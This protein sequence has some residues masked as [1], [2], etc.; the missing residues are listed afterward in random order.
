MPAAQHRT[1]QQ[2]VTELEL[3]LGEIANYYCSVL[4]RNSIVKPQCLLK[5][6]GRPSERTMVF[7]LLVL[8]L[9]ISL[10]IKLQPDERPEDLYERLMAFIEDNLLLRGVAQLHFMVRFTG[11]WGIISFLRK[12]S[13]FTVLIHKDLQDTTVLS[14]NP[15]LLQAL[16]LKFL[17][18]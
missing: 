4:S 2:K 13:C 16:N 17:R 18:R 15:K 3:M 7:N 8:I 9:L 6:F 5:V 11:R 1:T 10:K 14:F 12:F